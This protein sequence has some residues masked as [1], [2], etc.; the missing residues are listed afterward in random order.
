MNK[1]AI[2][3]SSALLLVIVVGIFFRRYAI[4]CEFSHMLDFREINNQFYIGSDIPPER[5][6]D[7]SQIVSS[8]LKRIDGVYGR[9]ES[10]PKIL[11]TSDSATAN[12][13][14]AN[15]TATMHRTPWRSCII[16]G[17]KGQN[18]DVIA[19]EW[20][21]AEIQQRVGFWRFIQE[22]PVWFDEGVALTLD[23][24]EPFLPETIDLSKERVED[25]RNLVT[26]K[27]FFSG[28]IM[29]HYKA[30]RMAVIPLIQADSFYQ[31]LEQISVGGSFDAVFLK[32]NKSI[33]PI[34]NASAD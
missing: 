18:V 4:A 22:V 20:L 11:F 32:A 34:A 33:Q 10:T 31:K 19:H 27:D 12:I 16:V 28:N 13:F 15:E 8:A 25:V 14:G 21:H 5:I 17:P 3:I 24:R 9:P 6:E 7:L 29:E 2:G 23:H 30:A 1:V 26:G